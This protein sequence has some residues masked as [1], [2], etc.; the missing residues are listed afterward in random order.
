[1]LVPL[2]RR[3][4]LIRKRVGARQVREVRRVEKQF[5][6]ETRFVAERELPELATV[7]CY[8]PCGP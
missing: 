2:Q 3:G 4:V 6:I 1:M 7:R 5:V 8:S